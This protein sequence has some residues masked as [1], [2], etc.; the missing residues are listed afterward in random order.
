VIG[1]N[2]GID[3][4]TPMSLSCH[5]EASKSGHCIRLLHVSYLGV[6]D[7]EKV[8]SMVKTS[9][10]G[11]WVCVSQIGEGGKKRKERVLVHL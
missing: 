5:G 4:S 1:L 8:T 7:V 9:P 11:L 3:R 6:S 2:C 10:I